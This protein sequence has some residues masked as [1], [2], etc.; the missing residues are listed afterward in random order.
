MYR[1]KFTILNDRKADFF[2]LWRQ[3]FFVINIIYNLKTK[4]KYMKEQ[5]FYY[6]RIPKRTRGRSR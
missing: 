5:V 1:S 6:W 3:I 2:N 4:L